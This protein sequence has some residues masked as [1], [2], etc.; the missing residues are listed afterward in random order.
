MPLVL[1]LLLAAS[2]APSFSLPDASGGTTTL[3]SFR[4][5]PVLLVAYR[6]HW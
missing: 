3:E 6:G 2:L 1:S 4:G 5:E